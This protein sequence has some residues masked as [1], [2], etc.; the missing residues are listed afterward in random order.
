MNINYYFSLVLF[1]S[2][3]VLG[4]IGYFSWKREKSYISLCLMTVAIY[5]FGYAFELLYANI[6]WIKFWIKIEYLGIVFLPIAWLIFALNFTGYRDKINKNNIKFL[7]I[8]PVI[9]LIMNYTNDFHHLF[10]I[11]LSINYDGIFPIAEI[12]KGPWY[13]I[14]IIYTYTLMFIGLAVF[15]SAYFKSILIVRKQIILLIIAWVIPW[16][17]DIIYM[18]KLLPFELDLC[19]LAFTIAGIISSFAI[20]NYRLIK[21]TP[22]AIE[23]VFSNM[24]D[25]VIILDD[26]NNVVNFNHSA[27]KIISELNHIDSSDKKIEKLLIE[28]EQILNVLN[29]SSEENLI[30]IRNDQKLKYYKIDVNHIYASSGRV[31]GKILTF[32]DVTEIELNRKKLADNYNFLQTLTDAIPNPIYSKD[33]HGI[34]THCNI[35]LT[36]FLGI[37][38]EDVIGHT[39]NQIFEKELAEIYSRMDQHLI[40]K[41]ETGAY[42]SKLPYKDG[43][44][45]HV[46]FNKSVIIDEKGISRGLAGVILD[47][48]EQKKNEEKINKLLKLKDA[49][50]KIGYSIN[51]ITNINDLLQLILNEVINCIDHRS[52]GSVLILDK[53]KN[54]KIAVAK[55]YSLEDIINFSITLEEH[56]KRFNQGEKINQTVILNGIDKLSDVNMLDTVEGTCIKSSICAPIIIEGDLYGFLNIDSEYDDIFNALEVELMEYMRNQAANAIT[57]HRM[58][59]QILYLSRYD[60]LTNTY[61]RSY[62]EQLFYTDVYNESQ[63]EF[64]VVVFDLNG[65]KYINDNYGHLIGDELIKRFAT[66]LTRLPGDKDIIARFGG[67]EFVAVFFHIDSET[68]VNKI[69]SLNEYFNDNPIKLDKQKIICS[70]S[71]GMAYYPEEAKEYNDLIKI[72]DERMYENKREKKQ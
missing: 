27:G 34:Y 61:N 60:K 5:Q 3:F 42:E 16:I 9:I 54:L 64:F 59:E 13:W 2:T 63:N 66:G 69:E 70:F 31:I 58:Y 43:S 40:D 12:E 46:I 29:S 68:L 23:K 4:F 22:I 35:A 18:F 62:F 20:L 36:D 32:N 11:N 49:M 72:A 30:R 33:K 24:L 28:Y 57:K 10:Y 15:I 41:K 21:L 67:D 55:G 52:N 1:I 51:E 37:G 71:Y 45:H 14:N 8:M 7:F 25:G 17:S 53:D 19:P 38:K 39:A 65:L 56:F 48:T 6:Q 47:I 26:Q 50:I 44:Y